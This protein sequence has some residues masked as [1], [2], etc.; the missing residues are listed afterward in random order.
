M[1]HQNSLVNDLHAAIQ[2]AATARAIFETHDPE[3]PP[4]V[5]ETEQWIAEKERLFAATAVAEAE[6]QRLRDAL[7]DSDEVRPW[8]LIEGGNAYET[9]W[10]RSAAAALRIAR[11]NVDA[12]AYDHDDGTVYV[13]IRVECE[14]TDELDTDTVVIEQREPPCEEGMMHDWRTPYDVLGG[15]RENPGIWGHGGGV[16]MR[17][18]CRHCGRYRIVD[19]W[20]QRPDTG[21]QG[22]VE[23]TYEEPDQASL[24]WVGSAGSAARQ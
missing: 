9:A 23:T 5:P 2:S 7:A 11:D 10:A 15:L 8:R 20:A 1:N 21:E 22:L 12:D 3:Q 14:L 18:L 6:V 17:S 4:G 16:I 24:D 19:T 13:D